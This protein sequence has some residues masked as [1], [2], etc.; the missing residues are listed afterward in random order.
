MKILVPGP[1]FGI[2][3]FIMKIYDKVGKE[4]EENISMAIPDE[5]RFHGSN[6]SSFPWVAWRSNGRCFFFFF[7]FDRL[8]L[9]LMNL[10][11]ELSFGFIFDWE[12][13]LN[14]SSS[15]DSVWIH[16]PSQRLFLWV[17]G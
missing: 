13:W 4:E 7:S 5:S 6:P 11:S 9:V 14:E 3:F 16:E 15:L 1:L 17:H 2:Y 10:V 12:K 8:S